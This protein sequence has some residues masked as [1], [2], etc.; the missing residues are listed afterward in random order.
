MNNTLTKVETWLPV[1]SG[2]YGTIW[3]T[4]SDEERE[5]EYINEKRKEKG[6]AP[7]EW[8]AIEW[9]YSGYMRE[10]AEGVTRRIASDL[11]EL[12]L[13]SAMTFQKVVSP[14]EYNFANDS[15]NIEIELTQENKSLI[16]NYLQKHTEAFGKHLAETYT[17]RSGFISSYPNHVEGWTGDI[18]ETLTDRHKLGSVLNFILLNENPKDY[19]FEIYEQL[20]G[21]GVTLSASNF[22]EL[23][24]G[25][26]VL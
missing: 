17:S 22:T 25:K 13:I 23:V 2:F 9:D 19:E 1:F 6:L 5:I 10:A 15:V 14:R 8:D 16:K 24:E 26:E 3:E 4:D 21:N 12:G 18:E 20:S 7:V 11:K